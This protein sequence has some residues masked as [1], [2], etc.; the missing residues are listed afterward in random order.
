MSGYYHL[1]LIRWPFPTVPDRNYCTFIAD[2]Q[3]LHTD[4]S[5]LITTLS[6]RE[7]STI[8]L[9]WSWFGAGKTHTLFYL[10]N[11]AAEL[12]K[13]SRNYSLYTI[14]SEF[15]KLARSFLDLYSSFMTSLD[16]EIFIDAFLE[17]S[18][19]E[20]SNHLRRNLTLASPDLANSL[21]AMATGT[22]TDQ[23]T[24]MRWLRAEA[25]P[26]TEF[27]RVGISK[28]IST[29]EEATRILS[30]MVELLAVSAHS[31]GRPGCRV[32]WMIDE[33]QRIERGGVRFRDEIN[34]GLHSTFNAC[35]NY[36]SL[37]LSF[38]GKPK[39]N[40]LP[41]W[42][43]PELRDRI[44]RTK[45]MILPPMLPQEALLFVKDVLGQFRIPE[46]VQTS[47]YF[48]FGED[49]CKVIIEEIQKKD[50]LK[51]RSIMQAFNAVLQEADP[52]IEAGE[53]DIITPEFAR[54]VLGDYIVLKDS[55]EE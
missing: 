27:R 3:Q 6:R 31:Q 5:T 46:Y 22:Q 32:M 43:S 26:I 29:S 41:A 25:L 47:P 28:K 2:R 23:V 37:F 12:S 55:E 8:H 9:F 20:D 49:A 15:P 40:G 30:T 38:S 36:L 11:Q 14:Y 24:A 42:F 45:V 19:C 10:A 17:V 16:L 18:T 34:T 7:T 21:Q 1:R 53:I 44:G 54:R 13:Y 48:P 4:I 33:F 51:P 35:P 39:P 50:E 52:K